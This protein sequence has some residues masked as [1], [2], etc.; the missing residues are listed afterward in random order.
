MCIHQ[1]LKVKFDLEG[2]TYTQ[3]ANHITA[4]VSELPEYNLSRKI[5]VTRIWGG[6]DIPVRKPKHNGAP[7]SGIRRADGKIYTG[8]MKHWW[9]LSEAEKEQVTEEHD[10]LKKHQ[11]SKK[12]KNND[13]TTNVALRKLECYMMK[14]QK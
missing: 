5:S 9:N 8:L 14:L 7:K 13:K 10:Q 3:A 4:A 2:L 6:Y 12:N 1:Q 11:K